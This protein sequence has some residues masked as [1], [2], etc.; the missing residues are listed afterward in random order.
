[1][2]EF[3]IIIILK[4][5]YNDIINNKNNYG[6]Q[7]NDITIKDGIFNKKS[8]NSYGKMKIN[9]E[10]DF[11]LYIFKNNIDFSIPKLIEYQDGNISIEYIPNS[12]VLTNKIDRTNILYYIDKIKKYLLNIHNIQKPVQFNIIQHDI[13]IELN[14]KIIERFN[15][16]DWN[17][18]LFYKSI[19]YV[20][21]I[22]IKKI[23]EYVNIIQYK[24]N[25]YLKDR[26]YYNLI[27]GDIH[28]GNIL[29][30][31]NEKI[32]FIDPRGYFGETKIFGLYEYDYAKLMFGLSGYSI[33]DNMNINELHINDNNI[34]I[35]FI[36]NYEYVF[37]IGKFDKI[38]TLFCLS[39]WLANNSCF[40][41]VNKKIVS[42]MIACY[43]CEKYLYF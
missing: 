8:K 24:I 23:T 25:I 5:Y 17:S 19:Q 6:F 7:F 3:F 38:T 42:L 14:K 21:N 30:D 22:K 31:K 41:D 28:L 36:K 40:L 4:Y 10:I 32:Y 9:N 29:M 13:N 20:N 35:E 11:Y 12:Y 34:E 2:F 27:H 39:I 18:C 43:Y 37:E 15:E 1:M 33:F 26:N 16:F